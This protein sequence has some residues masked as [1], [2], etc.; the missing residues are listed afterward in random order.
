MKTYIKLPQ[1]LVL[2]VVS[3]KGGVGKSM[4]SVN[5]AETF[6]Q[7]GYRTALID[8]DLGLS[9]CATLLNEQPA[10][11]VV[12][13]VR[14]ECSLEELPHKAGGITLITGSDAP[15]E[16]EYHPDDVSDALDQVVRYV[17]ASHEVVIIDTPA[18]AGEV[19]LW[20]LDRANL[21]LIVLVDEPTAISDA[22]RFC[23]YVLSID[24]AYPFAS[25]VNF[26]TDAE[27]AVSVHARF[28]TILG[29][30]LKRQ[31]AL[32]GHI[33][34]DKRVK[35]AVSRQVPVTRMSLSDEIGTE[36]A[37]V[38]MNLVAE[39]RARFSGKSDYAAH[40]GPVE[41]F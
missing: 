24:P 7:T 29:Y 4:L 34:D 35:E 8:A 13:W 18:G 3:G 15:G 2:A 5:L 14:G 25:V 12:N 39:A 33:P 28:N 10:F 19:S 17:S 9:N 30:F 23:K 32:M 27:S 26:A 37:Y 11:T 20:A 1:T 38:T 41:T 21:G 6:R 16:V 40:S 36:F 31:I 22:Y